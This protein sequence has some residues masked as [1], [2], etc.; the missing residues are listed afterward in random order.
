MFDY[1]A[2]SRLQFALTALFHITWPALT[3]GL[4]IFLVAMEALWLKT[5]DADYYRHARFWGKLFLLNFAV[6][7]VTGLPM[8]FQ[9]GMNWGPFSTAGGDFFGS[10]LGFEGAMAFM[11]EAGFLG[12]MVFGWKRISPPIHLFATAMVALGASFSAFW[13]MVANSWMQTPSGGYF[14]NGTFV[15]TS[16]GQAIMNPDAPFAV[17]HMWLACLETSLFVV[18]GISAWYLLRQ[19]HPAFF[20]KS[21]RLALIAAV[22]VTPLQIYLG[23][24]NG[25]TVAEYQPAKNGAIEGL[26]ETNA[27]GQGAPWHVLAWPNQDEQKNDWALSIPNLLS[28]LETHSMT[29]QVKGLREIPRVDQP[30]LLP[31]LFYSFRVMVA[32]GF[33]LFFLMLW[34]A[35]VWFRH[36]LTPERTLRYRW[37]LRAWV[38]SVPLGYLAVWC[39]WTVREVGRQPWII[40][41]VQRTAEGA[42]TLPAATVGLSLIAYSIVYTG[43]FLAFLVFA[44]RIL[45]H[46]PTLGE[47]TPERRPRVLVDTSER[48]RPDWPSIRENNP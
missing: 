38:A 26:W 20:I 30:P 14:D 35:W 12:I 41:G 6:G 43:L 27:P 7:V 3:I 1:V 31:L 32:I 29:G 5:G 2:L 46:G 11:L 8:E 24:G 13:I 45:R 33:Y 40:Y 15:I 44:W 9:F 39:G 37:L 18:G 16:F 4:S 42:S 48:P 22:V 34:S 36:D 47:P 28:L 10:V 19:R 21:F 25:R 23:D 17:S